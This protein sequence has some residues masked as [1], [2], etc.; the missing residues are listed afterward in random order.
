MTES[1]STTSASSG[2]PAKP[3]PDFPLFAHAAGVWAKKIRGKLHY[4]GPWSDPDAALAKYLIQ[5]DA[6]HS[7][8]KPRPD[9]EAV[10]V[11]DVAN[12]FLRAK[13]SLV[14]VGELSP[15]TWA[16]YKIAADELVAHMGKSRIVADLD[17]QDFATL[18]NRMAKKWGFHRLGTTIQ[19]VRSIF[20]HTFE[21]G[22]I[23]TPVRVG[24]NFKRPSKKTMRLHRAAQGPKLFTADEIRALVQGALVVG[25][26]GPEL[27][28][29]GPSMRAMILL[30]INAGFGNSDCAHLPLTALDLDGGIIDFARPKT[31]VPRRCVLW[32]ETVQALRDVLARRPEPKK[33]EDRA[34]VFITKY[35]LSW[36]KETTT[37]PVSQEMAKLLKAIGLNGR[38]ALGFY[39]L[40]H[41][42]RTIADETK[43][44]PA[45]YF[46]MGHEIP[47]MSSIYRESIS[48]ERLR[49]VA[50]HVRVWLFSDSPKAGKQYNS[51]NGTT[52]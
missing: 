42:F 9:S 19:Y 1:D 36:W 16:G 10:T 25:K 23:P 20:K 21:A 49:A 44:Q 22:L 7:G 28:E 40:R 33:D 50:D 37:N 32:P 52:G 5:K 8:R 4:F 45:V 26:D 39:T 30:G 41:T 35:G 15:R 29:A 47:D 24:P 11:E 18:R 27:V 3:Y 12:S 48:D 17:P 31:G 6:L 2:K 46:T 43:D 13:Q 14:D 38:K 34:L 51:G